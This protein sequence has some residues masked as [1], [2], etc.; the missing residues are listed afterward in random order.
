MMHGR[1]PSKGC[2]AVTAAAA[3]KSTPRRALPFHRTC[4]LHPCP[5]R[6]RLQ[7]DPHRRGGRVATLHGDG[8]R[9]RLSSTRTVVSVV[10]DYPC[11]P[12]THPRIP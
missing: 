7:G 12:Y 10:D 8:A 3:A 5:S 2:V 4:L 9:L 1:S 11:I 6:R